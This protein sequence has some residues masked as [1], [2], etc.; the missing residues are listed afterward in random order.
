MSPFRSLQRGIEA[1]STARSAHEIRAGVLRDIPATRF[2]VKALGVPEVSTII[3]KAVLLLMP[4]HGLP[5][6]YVIAP[7]ATVCHD[8]PATEERRG[9]V[10]GVGSGQVRSEITQRIRIL[11]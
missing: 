9:I 8:A 10:S 6:L 5:A 7:D 4:I 11:F 2:Q 3:H 1:I